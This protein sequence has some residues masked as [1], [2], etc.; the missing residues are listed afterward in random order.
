MIYLLRKYY[1]LLIG[2]F[3]DK[4]SYSTD[5]GRKEVNIVAIFKMATKVQDVTKS[6]KT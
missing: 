4:H 6:T 1:N 5:G 3:R 2:I